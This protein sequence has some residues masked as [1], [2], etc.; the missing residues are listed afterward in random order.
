MVKITCLTRLLTSSLARRCQCV[1]AWWELK[2]SDHLNESY[3]HSLCNSTCLTPRVGSSIA[4]R[5]SVRTVNEDK[6]V[7][8][9]S[10]RLVIADRYHTINIACKVLTEALWSLGDLSLHRRAAACLASVI[11][12][13]R[14]QFGRERTT[15]IQAQWNDCMRLSRYVN[16]FIMTPL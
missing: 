5:R 3:W 4:S 16:Q 10:N 6:M 1:V 9:D 8:V 15:L 11:R 12:S 13:Q 14:V 2:Q 7:R